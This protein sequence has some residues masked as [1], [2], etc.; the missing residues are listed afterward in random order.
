MFYAA[1]PLIF[2][3]AKS[4]RKSPTQAESILWAQ[5]KGRRFMSLKFRFQHP[6][7]R[8]VLDFY[9]HSLKLCIE[10]D[11]KSHDEKFQ[12]FYDD[13]RTKNLEY[14]GISVIRFSNKEVNQ[15]IDL[16]LDKLKNHVDSLKLSRK[17]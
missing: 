2:E 12:K 4:L 16:V 13:D 3:R 8:Y 9:C 5:L 10:I 1:S 14:F 11:G 15:D 7:I 17:S 6:A